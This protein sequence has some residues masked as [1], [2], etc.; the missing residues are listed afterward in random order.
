MSIYVEVAGLAPSG[1]DNDE[2]RGSPSA[3]DPDQSTEI[4]R[5]KFQE[6]PRSMLNSRAVDVLEH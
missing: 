2:V 3:V 6:A 1:Y 5:S 4:L